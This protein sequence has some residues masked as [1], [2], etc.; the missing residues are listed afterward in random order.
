MNL[1]GDPICD[2]PDDAKSMLI[3]SEADVLYLAGKRITKD[4]L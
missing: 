3:Q 1:P 4:V 2:S